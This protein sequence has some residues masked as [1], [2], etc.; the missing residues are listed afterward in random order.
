MDWKKII[1]SNRLLWALLSPLMDIRLRIIIR[2][3]KKLAYSDVEKLVRK[4]YRQSFGKYPDL[5]NPV[6]Y[7]E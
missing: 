1:K 3:R 5:E 6:T 7:N 4:I 2:R